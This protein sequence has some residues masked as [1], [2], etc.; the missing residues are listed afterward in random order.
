MN[1]FS[2]KTYFLCLCLVAAVMLGSSLFSFSDAG[3][4]VA[5]A[6]SDQVFF[7]NLHSHTS[8]SDGSGT[9]EEA[10]KHARDA[11]N[12]KLDFMALT[13]HNHAE[14]LGPD[15]RGIGT[16]PALYKGSGSESLISTARRMTEDGR[17]VALY[18]Q[19]FS[20]ISSGNHVNVFEIGE[21]IGV[22]KG[23]FDLLLDFLATNK[24][25]AG[26]P[27]IIMF[28]HPK[29][30]LE[31]EAKEYGRDDFGTAENWVKRM[32]AQARLIQ[33][34]NGPGQ[35]A[36]ENLDPARPDEDAFFKYLNMGFKV[37]PTA[38]QDN[39]EKNWGSATPARTAIVA[40]ALTKVNVLDALR[41]R[42]V[43]A[44]EDKNLKVV[45]K[46]NGRLCG[47]VIS[48][49]PVGELSIEYR[50]ADSDEPNAEYA[51]QVFRDA[52]GGP[53]A[54]MVTSVS[55]EPGGGSGM[56]EDIAISNAPQYIFFKIVQ[57]NED[58]DEEYV[59]TAP[60]WFQ[61][62][63]DEVIVTPGPGFNPGG[64]GTT[65]P[66]AADKA[67]ASRNSNTFHVSGSCFDAQ[68]IKPANLVK[69]AEARRGRH[70][71]SGCPRTTG[72]R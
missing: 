11:Q 66:P 56:I 25:S 54:Q 15:G 70:Q 69:G 12:A 3:I 63:P 45:I 17:F 62:Q 4:A 68:R 1:P 71:H 58:G 41:R 72:P 61:N 43:Y 55:T 32:G 21:V 2:F 37:A 34:I 36:G 19:E 42:H 64:P 48:P 39:H 8:Y 7:G 67:V 51:I 23:R 22:Q 24:D 18:G 49:V 26:Q 5:S 10:Y 9:P 60:V 46:V 38:D 59:W 31:V 50:I 40:P 35:A 57:F 30:T 29:N 20:T 52:V 65:P 53:T 44:T 14:A 16:E 47:D 27:A 13:E 6:Q 33:I 28:N